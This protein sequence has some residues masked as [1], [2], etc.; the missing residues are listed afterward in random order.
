MSD[1]QNL[2]MVLF[3]LPILFLRMLLLQPAFSAY[4]Q[5]PVFQETNFKFY[6][7]LLMI[8]VE[9]HTAA[10]PKI[11]DHSVPYHSEKGAL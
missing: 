4:C 6:M 2:I 3:F 11:A 7:I 8:P 9:F 1:V 10:K 5:P